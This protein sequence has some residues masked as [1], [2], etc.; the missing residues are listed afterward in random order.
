MKNYYKTT[1]WGLS[2]YIH[3]CGFVLESLDRTNPQRVEFCFR[4]DTGLDA[5]CEEF[6]NG[7]ARVNPM[8]F[9]LSQKCLKQRLYNE[10]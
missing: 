2:S 8:A 6:W 4:Y 10:K 5:A 1:D 7:S 9:I 3:S